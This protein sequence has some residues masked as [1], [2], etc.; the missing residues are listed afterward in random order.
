M[1]TASPSPP[2]A[3]P[4][5]LD[6]VRLPAEGRALSIIIPA[7]DEAGRIGATL[8]AIQA[9]MVRTG[10]RYEAIVVDD[11]SHD[12][13]PDIVRRAAR[14]TGNVRLIVNPSNRGKG[15]SVRQ[16]MLS[17]TG[18]LLLMYDADASAP[19]DQLERL[20]PWIDRGYDV[21]IGSRDAPEAQLDPPQPARRRRLAALFRGLRRLLL[22]PELRD[23]QCGFKLFRRDV[24]REVFARQRLDGWLFDCEVLGIADR[25]G[26]RIR[27]VGILWRDRPDSRV[28]VGRAAVGALPTLL[29][30]RLRLREFGPPAGRRGRTGTDSTR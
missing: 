5:A 15:Y 26:Y 2:D 9:Y 8:A 20:L 12:A 23:T 24:A 6:R 25:L 13:T 21:V 16:G 1:S 7:Y 18:D 19:I 30:I 28:R 3:E 27:E 29:W 11:G 14:A 4:A 10:R 22:L 17:A